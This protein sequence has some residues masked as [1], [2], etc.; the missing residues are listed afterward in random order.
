MS[1]TLYLYRFN[2]NKNDTITPSGNPERTYL[3]VLFKNET[4]LFKPTIMVKTN[5][6]LTNLRS[7]NYAKLENNFYFVTDKRTIRNGLLEIS[8]ERDPMGS[9]KTAINNSSFYISR[10]S[11]NNNPLI[12]DNECIAL[13]QY[14]SNGSIAKTLGDT[15]MTDTGG[16]S[17]SNA[18][19]TTVISSYG[20]GGVNT[21]ACQGSPQSVT[22]ELLDDGATG[23]IWDVVKSI[24]YDPAKYFTSCLILPYRPSGNYNSLTM[25]L[26]DAV[27]TI[28]LAND[29]LISSDR[30]SVFTLEWNTSSVIT[31]Y[32]DF[33]RYNQAYTEVFMYLPFVGKV[34]IDPYYLSYA[35]FRVTYTIDNVT[36]QGE[37]ILKAISGDSQNPS[38][39]LLFKSNVIVGVEVAITTN[40]SNR[41]LVTNDLI[42]MDLKSLFKDNA[43]GRSEHSI[44]GTNGSIG[45]WKINEGVLF[46]NQKESID[47]TKYEG[48]KG[49]PVMDY[50]Q[51]SSFTSGSYI[52]CLNPHFSVAGMT[53]E[54]IEDV[55]NYLKGGFY[56]NA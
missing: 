39:T 43:F 17:Y 50:K 19:T 20:R 38:D 56:Y 47:R 34:E 27:R 49:F 18:W 32:N 55:N 52:E 37:V 36:G 48:E 9:F 5:D 22:D 6:D 46:W 16:M 29:L 53:I 10:A 45:Q 40:R 24:V 2:K 1:Y 54:E 33:R 21:L 30:K 28:S 4:S 44:I 14:I 11:T 23:D 51:I 15:N 26:G 3:N 42:S 35:V 41:E 12:E 25:W 7:Y 31:Q 13:N 8:M